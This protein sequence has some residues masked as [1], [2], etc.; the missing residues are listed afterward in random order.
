MLV[1]GD[2]IRAC[3]SSL[4]VIDRRYANPA[5]QELPMDRQKLLKQLAQAWAIF[6]ESYAGLSDSQLTEPGVTG[7]RQYG[8]GGSGQAGLGSKKLHIPCAMKEGVLPPKENNDDRY[9]R[10]GCTWREAAA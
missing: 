9:S 4:A 2:P 6:K 8:H 1:E 7:K 5:P 10:M 3:A